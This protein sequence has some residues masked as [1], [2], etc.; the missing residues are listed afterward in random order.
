MNC[1]QFRRPRTTSVRNPLGPQT[2][3]QEQPSL[4]LAEARLATGSLPPCLELCQDLPGGRG[5]CLLRPELLT[6][7]PLGY[8]SALPILGQ[9][10]VFPS[11]DF[12]ILSPR[13][14]ERWG[15]RKGAGQ[16]W[17]P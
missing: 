12:S 5:W 9:N 3:S 16:E 1:G 15:N 14:R 13:G 4:P 6:F 2:P 11:C 10:A 8:F 17:E 7:T